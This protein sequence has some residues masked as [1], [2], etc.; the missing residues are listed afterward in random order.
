VFGLIDL[1]LLCSFLYSCSLL[2]VQ[3]RKNNDA[4]YK[5][6]KLG[7]L[8]FCDINKVCLNCCRFLSYRW[9][10]CTAPMYQH[11]S[12]PSV[13]M[14]SWRQ[15]ATSHCDVTSDVRR[16]RHVAVDGDLPQLVCGRCAIFPVR[17]TK[18]HDALRFVDVRRI[19]T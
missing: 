6:K 12:H 4:K 9:H 2:N 19:S 14:S 10:V 13:Q 8:L 18:L 3:R 5:V 7:S 11:T 17:R 15:T 16:E 1:W